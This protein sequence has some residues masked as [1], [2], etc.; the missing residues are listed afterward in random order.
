MAKPSLSSQLSETEREQLFFRQLQFDRLVRGG[1]VELNWLKDGNSFWYA[2]GGPNNT[3][4]YRVDPEAKKRKPLF[5]AQRVR[6]EV[7]HVLG[8]EPA[9]RGL[10]FDTFSFDVGEK[11]AMFVVEGRDFHLHL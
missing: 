8:H 7:T 6:D 9:G 10:P 3:V 11:V 4:I 1:E 2:E 5:D